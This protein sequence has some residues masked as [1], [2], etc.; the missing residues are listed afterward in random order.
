MKETKPTLSLSNI[1]LMY[2]KQLEDGT[3]ELTAPVMIP[4]AKDCD[5]NNG[6]PPLT[7]NQIA[8]FAKCARVGAFAIQKR[9]K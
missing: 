1:I 8:Q 9:R 5:Y 6:E 7:K 4:G 2:I 3:I